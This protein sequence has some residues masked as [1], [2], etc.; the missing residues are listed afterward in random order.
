MI[1]IALYK[2]ILDSKAKTVTF[3]V[4]TD[5]DR[6]VKQFRGVKKNCRNERA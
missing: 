3:T 1:S 2:T 5:F 6:I 4:I